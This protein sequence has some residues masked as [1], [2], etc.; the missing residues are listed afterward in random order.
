MVRDYVLSE[1]WGKKCREKVGRRMIKHIQGR[2]R[3]KF[4]AV[5]LFWQAV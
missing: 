1:G 3:T 4:A 5:F 2:R